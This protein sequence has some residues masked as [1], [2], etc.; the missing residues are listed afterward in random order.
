MQEIKGFVFDLDGLLTLTEESYYVSWIPSL[1]KRGAD[2][3]VQEYIDH[4]AGH[5]TVEIAEYLIKEKHLSVD[6]DTLM[7]EKEISS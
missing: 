1:R 2:L 4:C 7:D 6:L 5:S 3:S